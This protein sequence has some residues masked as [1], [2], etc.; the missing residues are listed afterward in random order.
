MKPFY[1]GGLSN[2][3]RGFGGSLVL[4]MYDEINLLLRTKG[5]NKYIKLIISI[6]LFNF[7]TNINILILLN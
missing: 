5:V 4:V 1:K 2:I 6:L 7:H 3:L